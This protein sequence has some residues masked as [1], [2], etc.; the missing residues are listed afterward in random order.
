MLRSLSRML[1]FATAFLG[2][3]VGSQ[4]QTLPYIPLYK[5]ITKLDNIGLYSVQYRYFDGRTGTMPPGWSG[6]FT[7]DTGI[8]CAPLGTQNGES[9]FFLGPIWR[10][11]GSGDTSQI[12]FLNMPDAPRITLT[13]GVAM[14]TG[15][16][17]PKLSDGSIFRVFA[18]H[19]LLM[20][21]DQTTSDWKNYTIDL[22]P[23]AGQ[24]LE[25]EFQT[26]PGPKKDP[27]FDYSLWGNRQ[28]ECSSGPL[29]GA[30]V[31]WPKVENAFLPHPT[32]GAAAPAAYGEGFPA[33][34]AVWQHD[35]N[36]F[37][38]G[39]RVD[40]GS[41]A[42]VPQLAP[43]TDAS[44]DLILPDGAIIS[45][46]SPSVQRT[47]L[48]LP[49]TGGS[50]ALTV[51][52]YGFM[53]AGRSYHLT[54]V[55]YK[56]KGDCVKVQVTSSSHYIAAV[57][58]GHLGVSYQ[59]I[60]LPPDYR[61][62]VSVPYY[63]SVYYLPQYR[64]FSNICIDYSLSHASE[65]DA[66]SAVYGSLTN[67]SRNSVDE[68]VYYAISPQLADVLPTPPNP[69]SPYRGVMSALSVMDI[70]GNTFE[71]NRQLLNQLASYGITNLFT[72]IH[73]WQHGGYDNE[74]P[75]VMPP[76]TI[77]GGLPA[78]KKLVGTAE[79]LGER[80]GLHENYVDYYPNAPSYNPDY[81]ALDS[82]GK[83]VLAWKN[84]IQSYALA[85]QHTLPIAAHYDAE[86]ESQLHTN[87]T[88]EDVCSAVP[89]WF[90]VDFN[91]ATKGAGEFHTVIHTFTKLWAMYRKDHNG[92]VLGEGNNHWYWSGLLD[93]AEAQFGTGWP[94]A[95][96][97]TAPLA[98][99]FDLL[100]VHPLELN[101][102]MGY[103]ER[104][105]PQG[106][107]EGWQTRTMTP[108]VMDVYRAQE[109]AY[110][111]SS[112]V[113]SQLVGKVA[114]VWQEANLVPPVIRRI[115]LS[116]VINIVYRHKH[117]WLTFEQ[118][119]ALGATCRRV[120]V[121]YKS[122]VTVIV[123]GSDRNW[124]VTAGK[125]TIDLPTSGWV[126][127]GDGIFAC[128]ASF[129]GIT[130][131]Y[132]HTAH[133]IYV[134]SRSHYNLGPKM[135]QITPS[136]SLWKST[137][138]RSFQIQFKWQ[139]G[140]QVPAGT[141]VFVHL[142][143][144]SNNHLAKTDPTGIV[145]VLNSGISTSPAQWPVGTTLSSPVTINLP[146]SVPAGDYHLRVG[147]WFPA[148]GR[149]LLLL[150]NSDD[151]RRV[152]VGNLQVSPTGSVTFNKLGT[153]TSARVDTVTGTNPR[154]SIVNFGPIKTNGSLSAINSTP[155][156]WI[157]H[158]YPRSIPFTVSM[159]TNLF[160]SGKHRIRLQGINDH[161]K[162]I[163]STAVGSKGAW[164]KFRLNMNAQA[165]YYVILAEDGG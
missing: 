27:S 24:R 146:A 103:L 2:I 96:G 131:D 47:A 11:G 34:H 111:H 51:V 138:P 158:T 155:G 10:G 145:E 57:H 149:R 148:G 147:I 23:Y 61:T 53:V 36:N 137:G 43:S 18:N 117:N 70:W 4:C 107:A 22:T 63:G 156:R 39:L 6:I 46:N 136:V 30:M 62:A 90:H 85:M 91:A 86:I 15:F 40:L 121:T 163:S 73:N 157:I 112:F 26:D 49:P 144:A 66:G 45:S 76:A 164:I 8:A 56:P 88:F 154:G 123:N 28:I 119:T 162:R 142:I 44:V 109:I 113:P 124:R 151:G 55:I 143:A 102:G 106:Y 75:D 9:A 99:N 129:S 33:L 150:G 94:Q 19:K 41:A 95:E 58:F 120:R 81:V 16:V 82:A 165:Q 139:V 14:R 116:P 1:L 5:G 3:A 29:P 100:K 98:V 83:P 12:F 38:S 126:A 65:L 67:G 97:E 20:E 87:G 52:K 21:Y 72:I 118:M 69:P 128:T 25:L 80:I 114:Y 161:G 140:E 133:R 130:G 122:G 141:Q 48:Q 152:L 50:N 59:G 160:G 7:Q 79:H 42:R 64:L 127:T 132:V 68:T 135:Y 13:F 115:A 92:P 77:L 104:W 101:H 153:D 110:G 93:G 159:M 74:L 37:L 84:L 134:N 60:L 125:R 32:Y 108:K 17:G 71:Q 78:M 54:T 105:S 89:P 35:G 31:H